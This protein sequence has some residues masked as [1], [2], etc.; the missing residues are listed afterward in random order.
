MNTPV[1][2]NLARMPAQPALQ[3]SRESSGLCTSPELFDLTI[4][5]LTVHDLAAIHQNASVT[6]NKL[7]K[8]PCVL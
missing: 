2:F 4:D 7:T 8:Q 1:Q 5:A 6:Q 3:T